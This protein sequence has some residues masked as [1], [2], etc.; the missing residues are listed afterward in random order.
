VA[1]AANT[2]LNINRD[3]AE[4]A[5]IVKRL[6]GLQKS[7]GSF[8]GAKESITMSGGDALLIESTWLGTLAFV[9]ASPNGEHEAELRKSVEWLNGHRG[10]YGEWGSTQSTILALKSL[11]AYAEH[12]RATASDGTI[13]LLVNGKPAGQVHFEK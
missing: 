1:L 3:G 9:K 12:S 7:D 6:V 4:T 10:G 13:T 8:P 11:T 2:M 5:A